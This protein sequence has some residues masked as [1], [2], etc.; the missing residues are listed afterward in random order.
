MKF[1]R[2]TPLFGNLHFHLFLNKICL[3]ITNF[4]KWQ[5]IT[6]TLRYKKF[7]FQL[8][9]LP[10]PLL[11][12]LILFL[13][14]NYGHGYVNL[15]IKKWFFLSIYFFKTSLLVCKA[16]STLIQVIFSR[17]FNVYGVIIIPRDIKINA[18]EVAQSQ[19]NVNGR[20]SKC[21]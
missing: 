15:Y 8:H 17:N 13:M 21:T 1:S 7:Q 6:M 14:P 11:L 16:V 3:S 18:N 19:Y 9:K 5:I 4:W 12:M 20:Y 10:E 2:A